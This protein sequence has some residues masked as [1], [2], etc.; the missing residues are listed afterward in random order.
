MS[1][2]EDKDIR[3]T[4]ALLVTVSF[5]VM[6]MLSLMAYLVGAI[7]DLAVLEKI[8]TVFGGIT[9][10]VIAFYFGFKSK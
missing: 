6:L 9:G 7:Q 10:I 1:S 8:A 2:V 3:G 4:L 5:I